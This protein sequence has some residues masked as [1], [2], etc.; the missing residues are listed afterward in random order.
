MD[1]IH[2]QDFLPLAFTPE[3]AIFLH[4]TPFDLNG[5]IK[6]EM[7]FFPSPPVLTAVVA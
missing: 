4:V 7:P 6:A 3:L 2:G 5:I 1:A